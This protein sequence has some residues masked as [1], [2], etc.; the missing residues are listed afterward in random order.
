MAQISKQERAR[1]DRIRKAAQK[2]IHKALDKAALM[3]GDPDAFKR[4]REHAR[5]VEEALGSW[6]A[7]EMPRPAAEDA[8]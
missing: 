3:F 8:A 4:A 6:A 2:T 1:R 5:I 7:P